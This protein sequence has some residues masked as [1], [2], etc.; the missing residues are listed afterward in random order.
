MM[1]AQDGGAATGW[2]QFAGLMIPV[3]LA[4]FKGWMDDRQRRREHDDLKAEVKKNTDL[5]ILGNG[6]KEDIRELQRQNNERK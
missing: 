3:V 2:L 6:V 1:F 5:T 4:L